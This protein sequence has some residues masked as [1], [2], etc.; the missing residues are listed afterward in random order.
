MS[1]GF[2]AHQDN[3][4]EALS[5]GIC[6]KHCVCKSDSFELLEQKH[7]TAARAISLDNIS[8]S[9]SRSLSVAADDKLSGAEQ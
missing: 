3:D 2:G 6:T 5:L 9:Q 8:Q 1:S 7:D 4:V